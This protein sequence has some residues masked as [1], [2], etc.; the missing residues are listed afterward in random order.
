M[1]K[2]VLET[3]ASRALKKRAAIKR[4]L[5]KELGKE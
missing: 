2:P 3:N 5:I 1:N 4:T